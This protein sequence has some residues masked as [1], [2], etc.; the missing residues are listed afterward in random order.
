MFAAA[1]AM[2]AAPKVSCAQAKGTW[3]FS[4]TL[5]R[6]GTTSKVSPVSSI[7]GSLGSCS[8]GGVTSAAMKFSGPKPKSGV[9]CT[10]FKSYDTI[11]VSGKLTLTWNTKSTSTATI[12]LRKVKGKPTERTASGT[13]SQGAFAGYRFTG[14]VGYALPKGACTSTGLKSVSF[15]SLAAFTL[16]PR[17]PSR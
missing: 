12:A 9:N 16:V 4:P 8:G 10:T 2:G 13:V 17:G 15:K 1:P 6:Y 11:A 7:A 3:S 14:L 5:P